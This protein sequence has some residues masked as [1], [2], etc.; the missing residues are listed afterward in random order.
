MSIIH[1][2]QLETMRQQWKIEMAAHDRERKVWDIERKA[3]ELEREEIE[4]AKKEIERELEEQRRREEQERLERE[5]RIR[6]GLYWDEVQGSDHCY[7]SGTREYTARL[8][9]LPSTYDGLKGCRSTPITIHDV[10]IDHPYK[11]ENRGFFDGIYGHF[12]VKSGEIACSPYWG[13]FIDKG[14]T[15][16]GSHTQR[17]ESRLLNISPG[18]NWKQM[19][20]TTPADFR[21]LHFEGPQYCNDIGI[22]GVYGVW[23]VENSAC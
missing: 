7:A 10:T 11:C 3:F 5:E 2:E 22:W 6:L 23:E 13:A 8:M 19:C 12:L 14:C 9:N 21:G 20:S 16:E 18:E 15:A 17:I 1:P 4:R